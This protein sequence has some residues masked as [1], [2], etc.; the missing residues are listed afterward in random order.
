MTN[1]SRDLVT[2]LRTGINEIYENKPETVFYRVVDSSE[3]T[4][5]MMKSGMTREEEAEHIKLTDITYG[6]EVPQLYKTANYLSELFGPVTEP[7]PPRVIVLGKQCPDTIRATLAVL[8]AGGA[9]VELFPTKTK[10]Q[11]LD[12]SMRSGAILALVEN[13]AFADSVNCPTLTFEELEQKVGSSSL[14]TTLPE[15]TVD[16]ASLALVLFTSGSTGKAKIVL[17]SHR[18]M[19]ANVEFFRMSGLF[20]AGERVLSVLY[21]AHIYPAI[22]Q[23]TQATLGLT[24]V[25]P[26]FRKNSNRIN[27]HAA[28]F[29]AR[30]GDC[31][32]LVLVPS[33]LPQLCELITDAIEEEKRRSPISKVLLELAIDS[34]R[35]QYRSQLRKYCIKNDLKIPAPLA[36]SQENGFLVLIAPLLA[37]IRRK[38][39]EKAFGPSV[40]A[41]ATGGSHVDYH[42]M[43]FFELLGLPLINGWGSTE[44]G[45]LTFSHAYSNGEA[46]KRGL[47]VRFPSSVGY[48]PSDEI[49]F[50]LDESG[51][52][53]VCSPT[54]A[55]GYEALPEKTDEVFVTINSKR[56]F[57]TEDVVKILD[58]VRS[59]SIVG[60]SGRRFKGYTGEW[61]SPERAESEL[62]SHPLINFAFVWGEGYTN[63]VALLSLD[64][65]AFHNWCKDHSFNPDTQRNEALV[66][67]HD[68]LLAY[69]RNQV[70]PKVV[71]EDRVS[72]KDVIPLLPPDSFEAQGFVTDTQKIMSR[73]I[74]D[75]YK[76][77]LVKVLEK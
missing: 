21:L 73:A 17:K 25:L 46:L 7:E 61:V 6:E 2:L 37:S 41:M 9:V 29:C 49:E 28:R 23:L 50:L 20:S 57:N 63:C 3:I 72:F 13:K 48:P 33:R 4:L 27:V 67:V 18:A 68:E 19:A 59:L 35:A 32:I 36:E 52:L 16:P 56:Y 53:F 43:E 14:P 24:T 69:A 47:P 40:Y 54:L 64:V 15:V 11:L 71:Q 1:S 44:A 66:L 62:A 38:V 76:E 39:I 75:N 42:S 12:E 77:T 45:I 70:G 74:L 8:L 26:G 60:R 22:A 34:G 30:H 58:N 10:D 5:K 55:D 65:N 31:H 51:V